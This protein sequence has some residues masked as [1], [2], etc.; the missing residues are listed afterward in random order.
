[1]EL[2]RNWFGRLRTFVEGRTA[3]M[4]A[5]P[6]AAAMFADITPVIKT[7]RIVKSDTQEQPI[8]IG[9]SCAAFWPEQMREAARA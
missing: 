3:V 6:F 9:G 5:H 2:G 7:G 8:A 4:I 1:M